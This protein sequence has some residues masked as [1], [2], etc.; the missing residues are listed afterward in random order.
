MATVWQELGKTRAFRDL[1][2]RIDESFTDCSPDYAP[3]ISFVN[4]GE[5]TGFVDLRELGSQRYR[6]NRYFELAHPGYVKPKWRVL[7]EPVSGDLAFVRKGSIQYLQTGPEFE[8]DCMIV[9]STYIDD[10]FVLYEEFVDP[11]YCAEPVTFANIFSRK[12][13]PRNTETVNRAHY[14]HQGIL[15]TTTHVYGNRF[16]ELEIRCSVVEET[17]GEYYADESDLDLICMHY[18]NEHEEYDF[19]TRVLFGNPDFFS[20]E[21]DMFAILGDWLI[22]KE[23][24]IF[25]KRIEPSKGFKYRWL[26]FR[27]AW[28]VLSDSV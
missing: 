21:D 11:S 8:E 28:S 6:I 22:A 24:K 16:E 27:D 17:D 14:L 18:S 4:I 3:H 23:S 2:D 13:S 19:L 5:Y 26:S 7:P 25:E 20:D 1:S 10:N 12:S 9:D 15:L